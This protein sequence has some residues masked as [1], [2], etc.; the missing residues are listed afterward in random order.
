MIMTKDI[1]GFQVSAPGQQDQKQKPHSK[2]QQ[3]R[4]RGRVEPAVK[5]SSSVSEFIVNDVKLFVSPMKAIAG[6][7]MR[8]I[9][10]GS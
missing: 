3:Q 10:R 5:S 6:E 7:F 9:K 2:Q 1:V 8:Q 4:R